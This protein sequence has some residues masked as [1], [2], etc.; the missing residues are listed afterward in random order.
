[1][2]APPAEGEIEPLDAGR[3]R[4]SLRIL[5]LLPHPFFQ[6]RGTP[7]AE[8]NLLEVLAD[9]GHE[10]QVLTYHEGEA[11]AI[12]GVTIHRIARI[13]GIR[14]I[15][16]GYSWK[17]LPSDAALFFKAVRLVRRFRPHLIHAVE[18][19]VFVAAALRR[20][21]GIPYVYDMD[22]S[23]SEQMVDRFPS[24][25]VVRGVFQR[26]ERSG[27]GRSTGVLAVCP[28]LAELAR[29]MGQEGTHV[30]LVE[31]TT[32]IP[33]HHDP[34]GAESPDPG[35]TRTI[36]YIGNLES[37]QGIDLL[38]DS[39]SSVVDRVPSARL[40]II[41]GSDNRIRQYRDRARELGILEQTDFAGPRPISEL[42]RSL[43]EADILVSPRLEG[44][45]TPMKIY[46][47]LASGRPVVATRVLSHTQ[48]LDEEVARLVDAD[49][50]SMA[51]GLIELLVE[52]E[53]GARL[54]ERAASLV[55]A[56]YG[57][58]AFR[59]KLGA[60]YEV[61]EERVRAGTTG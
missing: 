44:R 34:H 50:E 8:R 41:G 49:P 25:R 35:S 9:R 14:A 61:I 40:R 31:D 51:D 59:R 53:R 47:Y 37:Y 45:N 43:R 52:P 2:S 32:L 4:D 21:F 60:F 38:L 30:G 19:A 6:L 7:I 16:P 36:L 48:V 10:L 57:M 18:E 26:L 56:E 15:P 17:K 22:S 5:L 54:A 28:A 58:E 12:P 24:L 3:A 29:E 1:M 39:F 33:V 42:E 11:V 46:S 20:L 23:L 55:E 13:P 27:I